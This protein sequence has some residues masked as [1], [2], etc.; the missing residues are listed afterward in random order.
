[1][2]RPEHCRQCLDGEFQAVVRPADP[3]ADAVERRPHL[4]QQ[5]LA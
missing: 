5:T 3:L 1:M 4:A 2:S